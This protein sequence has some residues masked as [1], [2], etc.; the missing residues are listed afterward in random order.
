[1]V[2]YIGNKESG[3]RSGEVKEEGTGEGNCTDVEIT[4]T[5]CFSVC[6]QRFET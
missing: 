1:M 3:G 6:V 2:S 5:F 4:N